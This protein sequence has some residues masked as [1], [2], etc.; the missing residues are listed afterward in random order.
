MER[1]YNLFMAGSRFYHPIQV[2]YGDLDP[3]GHVNNARYLTYCEQARIAYIAHLGLWQGGSFLD[4][5]L[6]LADAQISFRAPILYGQALRVGAQITRMGNKSMTMAHP[7]ENADDGEAFAHCTAVLVAYDYHSEK[8]IR[9]PD[10][11][12][13]TIAQFEK[14]DLVS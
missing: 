1:R 13:Q 5:G 8:T 7:I 3:Q 9:I 12:R 2:R 14:I 6:I 11:W 4:F 10:H